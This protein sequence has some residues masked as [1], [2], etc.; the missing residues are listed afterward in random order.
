MYRDTC[1]CCVNCTKLVSR[2]FADSTISTIYNNYSSR[3]NGSTRLQGRGGEA[4]IDHREGGGEIW[5]RCSL[6]M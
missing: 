4:T 6:G 5:P 2:L 3:Y 1:T